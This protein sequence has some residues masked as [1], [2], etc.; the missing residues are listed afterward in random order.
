MAKNSSNKKRR[1]LTTVSIANNRT[2]E[3]NSSP[4]A[5]DNKHI[6]TFLCNLKPLSCVCFKEHPVI[7]G[8]TNYK[9]TAPTA[10][11]TPEGGKALPKHSRVRER[12]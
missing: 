10:L 4:P 12:R 6:S 3:D 1:K 11:Y 9:L 7:Q 5:M 8:T 2:N